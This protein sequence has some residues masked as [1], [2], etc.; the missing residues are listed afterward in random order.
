MDMLLLAILPFCGI[1]LLLFTAVMT[2]PPGPRF[3]MVTRA[4]STRDS[5]RLRE[6]EN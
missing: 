5:R 4:V 3:A 1:A 6:L 2:M